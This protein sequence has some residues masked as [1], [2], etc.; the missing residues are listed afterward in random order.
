MQCINGYKCAGTAYYH[1]IIKSFNT[2]VL[3]ASVHHMAAYSL[4]LGFAM[5]IYFPW[6]GTG[7]RLG[8]SVRL[9]GSSVVRLFGYSAPRY[10][11]NSLLPLSSGNRR[12]DELTH[13]TTKQHRTKY[14]G[15]AGKLGVTVKRKAYRGFGSWMRFL[16]LDLDLNI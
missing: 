10:G 6:Y 5:L 3:F 11:C 4:F 12:T 9:Y 14:N 2:Q 8:C 1:E 7:G 13:N 15:L 16:Y